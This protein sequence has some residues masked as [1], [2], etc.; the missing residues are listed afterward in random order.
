MI[1]NLI[2]IS[3][4]S[5]LAVS[6]F[7]SSAKSDDHSGSPA[8]LTISAGTLHS[9]DNAATA[10][11]AEYRFSSILAVA[12]D[13]N[14][15]PIIGFSIAPNRGSYGYAGVELDWKAMDNIYISPNFSV[16]GY[17]NG[18]DVDLGGALE[19]RSGLELAYECENKH[20][21]GISIAHISNAGTHDS[22]PGTETIMLN[23]SLPLR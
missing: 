19:F 22:N 15:R 8:L 12:G 10:F 17:E 13:A 9:F 6:F 16:A 23:Y 14:L 2:K 21:I 4:I 1:K 18:N 11:G 3:L 7:A 20:R 5:F